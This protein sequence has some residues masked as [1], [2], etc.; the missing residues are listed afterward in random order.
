[1]LNV[2]CRLSVGMT[3][4]DDR[5]GRGAARRSHVKPPSELCV[6]GLHHALVLSVA[7]RCLARHKAAD[8]ASAVHDA[9]HALHAR[10]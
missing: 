2:R 8:E 3:V 7:A 6:A 9:A 10:Y 1:M 5:V 4:K